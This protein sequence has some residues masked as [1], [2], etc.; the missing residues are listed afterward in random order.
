[1]KR[2]GARGD[3]KTNLEEAN[4]GETEGYEGYRLKERI[5]ELQSARLTTVGK[6]GCWEERKAAHKDLQIT[7]LITIYESVFISYIKLT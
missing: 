6:K 7:F 5:H 1:M 4:R 3:R 2:V